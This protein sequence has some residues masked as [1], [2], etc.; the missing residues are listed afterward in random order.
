MAFNAFDT[1]MRAFVCLR[2]Q[3]R[4]VK[5]R[6]RAHGDESPIEKVEFR[7]LFME[8]R[9]AAQFSFCA[10]RGKE[11]PSQGRE[12]PS[13]REGKSKPFGRKIQA[14]SFRESSLFKGLRRPL[15]PF[16]FFGRLWRNNIIWIK[17]IWRMCNLRMCPRIAVRGSTAVGVLV[18]IGLAKRSDHGGM[19]RL[20]GDQIIR[21]LFF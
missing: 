2:G 15:A 1:G 8:F 9:G 6:R 4:G 17:I 11:N 18:T 10:K 16:V 14:L 5:G 20:S 19:N 21:P 12:N 3:G 7:L 13:L